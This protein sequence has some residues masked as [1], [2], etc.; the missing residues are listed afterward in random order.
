MPRNIYRAPA[1]KLVKISVTITPE[2]LEKINA[3]CESQSTSISAVVRQALNAY[4]PKDE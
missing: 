1:E 2:Q 3:I 4:L